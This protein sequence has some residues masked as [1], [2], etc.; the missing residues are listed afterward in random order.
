M[1]AGLQM[2]SKVTLETSPVGAMFTAE[3]FF[4][5]VGKHVVIKRFLSR[6]PQVENEADSQIRSPARSGAV[7][8]SFAAD[9]HFRSKKGTKS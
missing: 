3:G 1:F 4:P 5:G 2:L 8:R 6:C 9:S 7:H